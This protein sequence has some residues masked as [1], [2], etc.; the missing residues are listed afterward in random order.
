MKAIKGLYFSTVEELF[1]VVPTDDETIPG[2]FVG[3]GQ[4]ITWLIRELRLHGNNKQSIVMNLKLDGRP[5]AGNQS[6]YYNNNKEV[7]IAHLKVL[8]HHNTCTDSFYI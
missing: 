3:L 7:A 5:F 8:H 2:Y 4:V 6:Y 1:S